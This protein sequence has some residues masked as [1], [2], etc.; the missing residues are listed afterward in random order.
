MKNSNVVFNSFEF[1]NE[2]ELFAVSTELYF[3]W[4][5]DDLIS[6]LLLLDK[7]DLSLINKLR[8]KKGL[9]LFDTLEELKNFFIPNLYMAKKQTKEMDF[10][11]FLEIL[12]NGVK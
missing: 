3:N 10:K 12:Y 11:I 8:K 7:T 2:M 6:K 1:E 9:S 4:K 5:I